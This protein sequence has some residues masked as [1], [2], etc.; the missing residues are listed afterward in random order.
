MRPVFGSLMSAVPDFNIRKAIGHKACCI[1]NEARMDK[2]SQACLG[3]IGHSDV[4]V[5]FNPV[6]VAIQV[7]FTAILYT[8]HSFVRY[9][10]TAVGRHIPDDVCF[11]NLVISKKMIECL[12]FRIIGRQPADGVYTIKKQ[13]IE[14]RVASFQQSLVFNIC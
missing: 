12:G 7:D 11:A 3:S 10:G 2:K 9:T 1:H 14:N 6:A 8:E 4:V 13:A 5:L